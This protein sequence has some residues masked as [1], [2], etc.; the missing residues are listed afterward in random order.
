MFPFLS[1]RWLKQDFG[2]T[3]PGSPS[4]YSMTLDKSVLF[5][6]EQGNPHIYNS[7]VRIRIRIQIRI[8]TSKSRLR[9]QIREK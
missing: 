3:S 4:I 6:L 1:S 7:D 9:I 5:G 8:R 2:A